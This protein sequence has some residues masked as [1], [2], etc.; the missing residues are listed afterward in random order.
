MVDIC[1]RYYAKSFGGCACASLSKEGRD[2]E[3]CLNR[4][5]WFPQGHSGHLLQLPR[6]A[7][8]GE[9]LEEDSRAD[10]HRNELV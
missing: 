8:R 4:P 3:S 5:L 1:L 6:G 9:V 7:P 10:T 2:S